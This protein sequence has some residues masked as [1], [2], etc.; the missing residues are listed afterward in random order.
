MRYSLLPDHPMSMQWEREAQTA[1]EQL[2]FEHITVSRNTAR[3]IRDELHEVAKRISPLFVVS[4]FLLVTFSAASLMTTDWLQ[5]KPQLAVAGVVSSCLA[6]PSAFGVCSQF[7]IPAADIVAAA[8]FLIV[9]ECSPPESSPVAIITHWVR[10]PGVV[11]T[12]VLHV[13]SYQP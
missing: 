5:S 12:L 11:A 3:S 2:R 6:I 13:F 1:V 7:G 9:G 8:P 10:L 4:F